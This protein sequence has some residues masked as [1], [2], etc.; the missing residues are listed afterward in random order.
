MSICP[1]STQGRLAGVPIRAARWSAT[2]PWRA[3][4]GW[5]ALVVVAVGLAGTVSTQEASDDDYATPLV[6][7]ASMARATSWTAM[8]ATRRPI[9]RERSSM[10]LSRSTL[11]NSDA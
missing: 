8:A 11:A 3:I 6:T 9:T 10:P 7:Q 2:H 5:L 4:L 1:A